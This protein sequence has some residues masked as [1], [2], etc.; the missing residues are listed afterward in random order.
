MCEEASL[1]AD[2][3]EVALFYF[4]YQTKNI[5]TAASQ[6]STVLKTFPT[7]NP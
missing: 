7:S 3:W 1:P 2:V 5:S 4:Y 6:L